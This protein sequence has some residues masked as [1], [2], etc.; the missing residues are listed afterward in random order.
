MEAGAVRVAVQA[1]LAVVESGTPA[2]PGAA[3]SE[4]DQARQEAPR[5]GL[6]SA[7]AA[8]VLAAG[9]FVFLV[10]NY[11][12][13]ISTPD[14]NGYFA[15]GRHLAEC[16][17]TFFDTE[18][19]LQFIPPHWVSADRQRYY[20]KYPPGLPAL[21]AAVRLVSGPDAT[22]LINPVLATLTLL[23]VYAVCRRWG[24]GAWGVIAAALIA[25]C[26]SV[27]QQA[28]FAFAHTA[29][30]FLLVWG[31]Y[32]A[33]R[34]EQSKR[35]RWALAAGLLFG[36][37]PTVRY[38]EALFIAAFGV[39]LLLNLH[40][41]RRA[42]ASLL[43]A[44]VGVG[45][46]LGAL[47]VR[48]QF[49]FGA[50]WRTGYAA[51]NE[52]TGFGWDYFIQH[53]VPY[54]QEMQG[55]G[56]GLLIGVGLVGIAAM[57]A[58][59]ETWRRGVLA[60]GVVLPI[61]LL[62]MAYY[63]GQG[64]GAMRFFVP[65]FFVFA[66]ATAYALQLLARSSRVAAI[67]ASAALLLY[68]CAWGLPDSL[69]QLRRLGHTDAALALAT[70]QVRKYVEPG[71]IVLADQLLQQQLDFVGGWRL[72]DE[73]LLTGR[74]PGGGPPGVPGGGRATRRPGAGAREGQRD[75][76]GDANQ[77]NPVMN[78]ARQERMRQFEGLDED[79]RRDALFAELKKW[80]AGKGKVYWIGP[81]TALSR[82]QS[83]FGQCGRFKTVALFQLPAR[84]DDDDFGLPGGMRGPGGAFGGRRG[85]PGGGGGLGPP[86]VGG[87][88]APGGDRF[89]PPGPG[90]MGGPGGGFGPPGAPFGGDGP[91]SRGG[92][93]LIVEWIVADRDVD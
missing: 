4:P 72:A 78:Q 89:G 35:A 53:A 9:Y 38:P 83:E 57:C 18:S 56:A 44:I 12:P 29:V 28:L 87:F 17:H 13:A 81:E 86:G 62:Y 67:G 64:G 82:M 14:A 10:A 48:N 84:D 7:F 24:G 41:H 37:I 36:A 45:L 54:L 15:Q 46:P 88:G 43:A 51:S 32:F 47:L 34:W 1:D 8:L 20:C 65:V 90:G 3:A 25:T 70:N 92:K 55:A 63:W 52:Q 75:T 58:Q 40:R 68:M 74:G 80:A 49:A 31:I 69:H 5:L 30:A 16:G 71:S 79:E 85:A 93:M 73:A 61:T 26:P 11:A 23:G 27:N 33:A 22:M 19:L 50:F 91:W 59:R 2:R 76:R 66:I 21:A 39:F 60:A 6:W 42:S 77:P